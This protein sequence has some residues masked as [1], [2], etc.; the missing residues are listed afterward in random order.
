MTKK[1]L[2]TGAGSGFGKHYSFE[3][4]RR[5]YDVY[6]SVE[7]PSQITSLR[8]EAEAE[9]LKLNVFKLNIND[10]IDV[11]NALKLD[12]DILVSN[13]GIGEGGAL[14]DLPLP[15]LRRQF[16]VNFFGTIHLATEFLKKF[17]KR[18]SGR[19]VFVSSI[20]GIISN[21]KNGA[22]CASKH[23]LE[24]A[25]QA[26]RDEMKDFNITVSTINPGPYL[27]GFN[28]RLIEASNNWYDKD[29]AIINHDNPSFAMDQFP[30]LQDIPA[31]V[32]VIVNDQ[33]KFRN[34]FPKSMEDF[35]KDLE[36]SYWE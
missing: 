17:A 5:G 18:K 3:L 13:A 35:V 36:K 30:E 20:A 31:M 10:E 6:A 11:Q 14:V 7:I 33:A 27:T 19:L 34:V 28:D 21:E 26:I 1:I 23:A 16:E 15:L 12:I 32:D 25:V 8:R 4:A 29:T 2:I 9:N 24:A 22:Y